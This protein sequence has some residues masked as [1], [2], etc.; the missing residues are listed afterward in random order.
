M[1]YGS[2]ARGRRIE[3]VEK[4]TFTIPAAH[5]AAGGRAGIKQL[6]AAALDAD[7][8]R[9]QAAKPKPLQPVRVGKRLGVAPVLARKVPAAG[10]GGRRVL[11]GDQVN[12]RRVIGKALNPKSVLGSGMSGLKSGFGGWKDPAKSVGES[13]GA[14]RAHRVGRLAGQGGSIGAANPGKTGLATG[15]LGT[16][17]VMGGNGQR[18]PRPM[19][20]S[21]YAPPTPFGKRTYDPETERNFRL[22]AGAAA[23]GIAGTALAAGGARQI[24]R[25]TRS[26][27]AMDVPH[28]RTVPP[29]LS[30]FRPDGKLRPDDRSVRA[31][32]AERK[33]AQ[34]SNARRGQML[35]N[36][37][38]ARVTRRAGGK[39]AGGVAL[40]G[41]SG[42]LLRTR[43]EDR[44]D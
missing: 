30:P 31:R 37:K 14:Q 29:P 43:N 38:G 8:K 33:N 16:A 35:E 39:V 25:D 28:A 11:T 4:G 26:L 18:N 9:F 20:P 17:A 1:G 27:K 24:R 22:G 19:T 6:R 40:L 2:V 12:A 42:A 3:D 15:A 7:L 44:W 5:T 34:A 21:L 10:R 13:V 41:G 23:T 36:K 32:E